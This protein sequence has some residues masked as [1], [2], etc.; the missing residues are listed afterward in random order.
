MVN[1]NFYTNYM[2]S[3]TLN[4]TLA[5]LEE[6]KNQNSILYD[7]IKEKTSLTQEECLQWSKIVNAMVI[8]YNSEIKIYEQHEGYFNLPHVDIDAIPTEDF[9]LY[10]HWTYDRIYRND[11][12]KQPDV[13]MLMLLFNDSFSE[14]EIRN[15]YEFYEPRCIHESSLSP[16]VHSILAMQLKK[17][18]EGYDF[19]EFTT[20]LDLDNY[21]RNSHEGLHTTSLVASWMNIVYGFGGMRSDGDRLSF[22]PSIPKEWDGYV[23]RISYLSH[24]ILVDVKKET[25]SFQTMDETEISIDVYGVARLLGKEVIEIAIPN[26]WRG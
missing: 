9:P 16:S 10:H 7:T 25:V 20:R 26:E 2:G 4:Y 19:F 21:N 15:N 22:N 5:V 1:N 17:H 13:L 3:F 18:S 8:P 6:V 11:M 14:E 24:V 23:F 12:L